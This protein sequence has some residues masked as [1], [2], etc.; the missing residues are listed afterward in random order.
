MLCRVLEHQA[1]EG[2]LVAATRLS[3]LASYSDI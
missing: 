1:D 2:D 3:M